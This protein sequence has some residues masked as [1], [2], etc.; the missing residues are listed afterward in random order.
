MRRPRSTRPP[1]SQTE[2]ALSR[3]RRGRRTGRSAG[4]GAAAGAGGAGSC[5]LCRRLGGAAGGRLG[6]FG[7]GRLQPAWARPAPQAWRRA[8]GVTCRHRI[9]PHRRSLLCA[10]A[11]PWRSPVWSSA[12]FSA[13]LAAVGLGLSYRPWRSR[14]SVSDF[15]G[16]VL[17]VDL[18][19]ILGRSLAS[20]VSGLPRLLSRLALAALG[21]WLGG[22]LGLCF[23]PWRLPR[24]G[25][26][27]RFW[28]PSGAGARALALRLG[29]L[30]RALATALMLRR[31]RRIRV[32]I[33][34]LGAVLLVLA[35]DPLTG[36]GC[37][38][39]HWR[40]DRRPARRPCRG[41]WCSAG[42]GS[43]A[44]S[45]A[46]TVFNSPRG[47]LWQALQVCAKIW[48]GALPASRFV[49]CART[50]SVAPK[51][52]RNSTVA[53]LSARLDIPI[54]SIEIRKI[55]PASRRGGGHL[56]ADCAANGSA[57]IK[58]V[59]TRFSNIGF[60]HNAIAGRKQ[61]A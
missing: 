51:P 26:A 22:G 49:A 25:R 58:H 42:A 33:L 31:L 56:L 2:C 10:V 5:R 60:E 38:W 37:R 13:G 34:L 53:R 29:R 50:A 6:R 20:S 19:F 32:G 12:G 52:I 39:R 16:A 23:L 24:L 36:S 43:P 59:I 55:Q 9:G 17:G 1:R 8:A 28:R 11:R 47:L 15:G 46:T 61:A 54:I 44:A 7:S 14:S 40:R 57:L 48:D 41:W 3:D 4:A 45:P 35:P 27:A 18:G 21:R 30:L